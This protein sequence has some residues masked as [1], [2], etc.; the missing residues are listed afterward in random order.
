MVVAGEGSFPGAAH[1]VGVGGSDD[2]ESG[3]GAQRGEV[4]DGLVGG[5]V[6]ADGDGVV[7]EQVE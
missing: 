7:G 1:F 5:S 3:D 4:F 2:V 6:F